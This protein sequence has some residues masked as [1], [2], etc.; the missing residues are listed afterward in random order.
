M[1]CAAIDSTGDLT[2][3]ESYDYMIQQFCVNQSINWD[4]FCFVVAVLLAHFVCQNM[5]EKSDTK[6]L[7]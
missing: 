3:V 6:C 5:G 4:S 2:R 7:V 1:F